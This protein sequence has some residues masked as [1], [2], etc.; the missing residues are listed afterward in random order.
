L[1]YG[2]DPLVLLVL[3]F[4]IVDA[5]LVWENEH[6]W[7]EDLAAFICLLH[8]FLDVDTCQRLHFLVFGV[9]LVFVAV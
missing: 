4:K 5:A 9:A 7:I 1:L 3:I 8:F 2:C 6:K